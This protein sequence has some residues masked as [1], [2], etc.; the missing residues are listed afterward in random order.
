[1]FKLR[2]LT[3][4]L[5]IGLVAGALLVPATVLATFGIDPSKVTVDNLHPGAGGDFQVTIYNQGDTDATYVITS[6]VPDYTAEGYET[7]PYNDWIKVKPEEIKIGA[8]SKGKVTV[9]I[10]MPND[11]VYGGKKAETWI[12]FKEKSDTAMVQIEL[13]SRIFIHTRLESAPE[14]VK[15]PVI[16]DDNSSIGISADAQKEDSSISMPLV[17]GVVGA[18]VV[19]AAGTITFLVRRKR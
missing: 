16:K 11:A 14:P 6:R 12:S 1:M 13:C 2:Q 9:T 15:S 19:V 8:G 3:L 5:V 18:V 7:L 17:V 4:I 10:A